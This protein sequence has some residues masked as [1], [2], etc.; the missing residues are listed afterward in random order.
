M[1][2]P[3][4]ASAV[5]D[6]VPEQYRRWVVA[7]TWDFIAFAREI[8][9]VEDINDRLFSGNWAGAVNDWMAMQEER[10]GYPTPYI[11]IGNLLWA[12]MQIHG[13][14]QMAVRRIEEW[15]RCAGNAC[16]ETNISVA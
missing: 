11:A 3:L 16:Q 4:D 14:D 9:F 6:K 12:S 15:S 13:V 8:E 10:G 1:V 7:G 5:L 2:P